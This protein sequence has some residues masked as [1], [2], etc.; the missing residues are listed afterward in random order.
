MPWRFLDM[1]DRHP[2]GTPVAPQHGGLRQIP[3]QKTRMRKVVDANRN[4]WLVRRVVREDGFEPVRER[5]RPGATYQ[6]QYEARHCPPHHPNHGV[7][8]ASQSLGPTGPVEHDGQPHANESGH[9]P[10][11]N[12]APHPQ[13]G[14]RRAP[15]VQHR[16]DPY[17][18]AER[19]PREAKKAKCIKWL[20]FFI[21]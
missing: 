21:S 8:Q 6:P 19:A 16:E 14:R 13:Q 15:P 1:Q 4:K 3:V 5:R 20:G 10:Q 17:R 2:R 7:R 9:R 18:A 11:F 12:F